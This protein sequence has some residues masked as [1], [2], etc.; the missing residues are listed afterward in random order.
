MPVFH[1]AN[2][3]AS[4]HEPTFC[5]SLWILQNYF[6]LSMCNNQLGFK[7]KH[8]T[9]LCVFALKQ[10]AAYYNERVSPVFSVFGDSSKALIELVTI[11]YLI[12]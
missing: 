11:S 1:F 3:S 2:V 10:V 7:A 4:A 12:I 6:F 8:D 9:D 5:V